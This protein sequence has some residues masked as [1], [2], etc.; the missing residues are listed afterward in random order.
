M[1][2]FSIGGNLII[3]TAALGIRVVRFARP[4]LRKYLY[5]DAD[6]GKC[7]LFR[8][9]RHSAL[10]DLARGWAL[11]V[12]LRLVE[13]FTA[14]LYRCLLLIRQEVLARQSHLVLCGLSPEHEEIFQLFQA[15]RLF[16]IV[17]TEAEAIREAQAYPRALRTPKERPHGQTVCGETSQ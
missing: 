17:R 10:S 2:R 16:T 11:L 9:V 4:D 7:P 5:D 3:E 15:H 6:I 12:N 14:A 13:P 1:M 8:E